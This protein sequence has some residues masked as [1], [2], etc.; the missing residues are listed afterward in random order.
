MKKAEL[1]IIDW[2]QRRNNNVV[3]EG[4]YEECA[5]YLRAHMTEKNAFAYDMCYT[6][7][8]RLAS[9]VL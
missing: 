7:S 8:G 4:S 9:F 2:R 3:F 5:D 6:E 1:S